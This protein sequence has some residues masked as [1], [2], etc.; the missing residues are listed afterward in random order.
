MQYPKA[1]SE[2]LQLRHKRPDDLAT[3]LAERVRI[4]AGVKAQ[5][6]GALAEQ[7]VTAGLEGGRLS[8]G[9]TSGAWASRLRYAIGEARDGIGASCGVAIDEVRI[10]VVRSRPPP[11]A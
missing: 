1:I 7:V 3:C 2:L 9:V 5:L 11:Q 10:R 6:P 4:L 8:L